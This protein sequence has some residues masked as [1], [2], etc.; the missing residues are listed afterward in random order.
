MQKEKV[1]PTFS[2]SPFLR[3]FHTFFQGLHLLTY[4]K[5]SGRSIIWSLVTIFLVFLKPLETQDVEF[6][7]FLIKSLQN[8]NLEIF[9]SPFWLLVIGSTLH[10]TTRKKKGLCKREDNKGNFNSVASYLK[11]SSLNF[12]STWEIL[13]YS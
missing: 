12:Q 10:D 13:V 1:T 7:A 4:L 3:L 2:Q 8:K 6:S 11:H 5:C 9:Y